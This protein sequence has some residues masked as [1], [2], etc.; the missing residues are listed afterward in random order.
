MKLIDHFHWSF[1]TTQTK[2]VINV[3]SDITLCRSEGLLTRDANPVTSGNEMGLFRRILPSTRVITFVVSF[4]LTY[5]PARAFTL[6]EL[7][8]PAVRPPTT[9]SLKHRLVYRTRPRPTGS[10]VVATGNDSCLDHDSSPVSSGEDIELVQE[11]P[12]FV[13]SQRQYNTIWSRRQWMLKTSAWS[14]WATALLALGPPLTVPTA[15]QALD[16]EQNR[17]E[18]FERVSP[19][20]VFI[21]TFTERRD[22]FSTS[23]EVPLGSGSGFV[24]DTQGH[25]ITNFH[26][27]RKAQSAQVAFLTTPSDRKKLPPSAQKSPLGPESTVPFSGTLAIPPASPTEPSGFSSGVSDMNG[28]IR[29]VVYKAT[30]VGADPS[31]DIVVLKVDAPKQ[32]LHPIQLGTSKGIKVGQSAL[33]IG[34]PFGLDHTLTAGIISGTGR[35]V[36]SPIGRPI[37]NVI[38]TDAAIN[39]GNSGGPLLD[40]HG[41]LIGMNTAIYS[42]SGASAGIGFAI[43]VDTV[44]LIVQALIRDG[45]I[46]RPVLGISVLEAKQ[47]RTLGIN[48]GVL[49][50]YV[51]QDSLA[52]K[53]G[54]RGTRRT[55]S[56][57]IEL[58]DIITKIGDNNIISTETDLFTSL[59]KYKPGDTVSITVYRAVPTGEIDDSGDLVIEAKSV[60]LQ[61]QLQASND[62]EKYMAEFDQQQ[63]QAQQQQKEQSLFPP[64]I[65]PQSS[66]ASPDLFFSGF[67]A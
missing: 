12:R 53:A 3:V 8:L 43:P 37:S 66:R 49:V 9:R 28:D 15:A 19:S 63:S 5:R 51:P 27:V 45:Q 32:L 23:V 34:N 59:E 25:I 38:Q 10:L 36:K 31:K 30:V 57:L 26:V 44:N 40:D 41:K 13:W 58:G 67:D 14:A 33:A 16:S 17:I 6:D 55:E 64:S 4:L 18:I 20:V 47:A 1:G 22:V 54:L 56:G 35:E 61:I 46:I 50:L 29:R 11:E 21:D 48:G 65:A 7:V 60:Q 24:W 2:D 39:P 42:P 62:L 52:A